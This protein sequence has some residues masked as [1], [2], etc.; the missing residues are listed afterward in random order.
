MKNSI[1]LIF[2]FTAIVSC[3]E[4]N[5]NNNDLESNV[6]QVE[7]SSQEATETKK[8]KWSEEFNGTTVDTSQW[9]YKTGA[10]GW[11]NDELQNYTDGNNVEVADGALKIIVKKEGE[12]QKV[13]DYTS[14][15][16]TSTQKVQYGHV[17]IR[18][19]MPDYKGKG[20]WPAL[21]MLGAD[22]TEIGWPQ[23]G[24]IDVM[25]YV[26]KNPDQ[27][28]QTIHS[29]ANNHSNGTQISTDFIA[30]PTI[31]EEFHIYGLLWKEDQ[32]QFYIDSPD[33]IT[34]TIDRPEDY[35]NENWPF[36]KEYYFILNIAVGGNLGG[37][38]DD[39]IFPAAMEVDYVRVYE[40][41]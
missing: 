29:V 14:A 20:I 2:I 18:A 38:V 28:L 7:S 35:N 39:L 10:T 25:E 5:Q 11:G 3:K 24:E 30:L 34:L 21:W 41:D 13:G 19:K 31:E 16:I 26:S 1:L 32:L 23:C 22:I 37:E 33:N 15:R 6:E 4:P 27:V 9:N 8:L 40:L 36:M 17:A 12:G